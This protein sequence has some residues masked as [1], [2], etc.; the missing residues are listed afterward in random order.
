[1]TPRDRFIA[2][3]DARVPDKTVW[4]SRLDIW[5][6]ARK[7]NGTLPKQVA[8]LSLP[9]TEDFLGMGRSARDAEVFKVRY[10]NVQERTCGDADHTTHK[11]ITPVGEVSCTYAHPESFRRDGTGRVLTKH[12]IETLRDYDVMRYVAEHTRY[13]AT[14]EDYQQYDRRIGNAGYPLV[15]IPYSPIHKI[16]MSYV[17]Y[18]QFYYHLAD[19][20]HKVHEL[21]EAMEHNYRHMWQVLA[22][23]PARFVLHG[24]HFS[25]QITPPP[26]FK[27]YFIPYFKQFNATMHEAGIKV[28]FHGD[29][30]VSNLLELIL[31]CDF[32]MVDCFA[33]YP[34]VSCTF[35]QARQVWGD[36]IIIWG[37]VPSTILEPDYPFEQFK[38]YM[39]DLFEK[40]VGRSHFIMAVS[41]NIMPGAELDRLLWIKELIG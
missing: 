31:E 3:L 21:L 17:G 38:A 33:T 39:T 18:E 35:D 23:S 37:G 32:D 4:V 25:S 10:E 30:D 2:V 13:Q 11:F 19:Y 9:E 8:H 22:A 20:P 5:Y 15:V 14:Y 7:R 36:K 24:T 34:L 16:M 40:T 12:Y 27:K 1:M 41:D 29:A 26:I 28:T 6:N